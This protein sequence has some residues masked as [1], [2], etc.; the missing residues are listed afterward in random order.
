MEHPPIVF[1]P[2]GSSEKQDPP[3]KKTRSGFISMD[4]YQ[5]MEK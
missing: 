3:K 5:P 4:Y 1:N 2:R